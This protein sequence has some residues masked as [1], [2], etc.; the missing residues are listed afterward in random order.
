[1]SNINFPFPLKGQ[2]K[3]LGASVQ[4]QLTAADMNNV[5]PVDTTE[6]RMRGG[7]RPGLD[8]W[9]DGDNVGNGTPIVVILSVSFMELQE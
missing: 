8:K 1:M 6:K 5:R 3:N 4:P 7:Q 9:G 2:N